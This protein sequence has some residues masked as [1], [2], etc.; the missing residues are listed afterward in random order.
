MDPHLSPP[1]FKTPFAKRPLDLPKT[2]P[3]PILTTSPWKGTSVSLNF[4]FETVSS[5]LRARLKY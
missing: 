1:P 5:F 2:L 3:E 4:G